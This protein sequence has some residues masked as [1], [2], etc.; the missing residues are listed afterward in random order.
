M[1]PNAEISTS[2]GAERFR[3]ASKR[4]A[5]LL[6]GSCVGIGSLRQ[7]LVVIRAA[8]PDPPWV[9]PMPVVRRCERREWSP[10]R[11]N[12]IAQELAIASNHTNCNLRRC[13]GHEISL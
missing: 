2:R 1:G 5:S 6:G 13:A 11:T 10:A 3:T 7:S 9:R 8:G 4:Q 12:V